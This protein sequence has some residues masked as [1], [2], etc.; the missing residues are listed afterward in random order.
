MRF[1][2]IGD[3][4]WCKY[5]SII[6]MRG[7]EYSYRLEN[8]IQS[9]TWAEELTSDCDSVIYLGDFFDHPELS[10]EE[11]TAIKEIKW[12]IKPH[13]FLVGNHEMGTNDLTYSSCHLFEYIDTYTGAKVVDKPL[14]VHFGDV[15]LHFIPYI[16]EEQ[17]KPFAEYL[18]KAPGRKNIVLSHNDISGMNLG[19]FISINGFN[20]EEI[21]QECDLFLNGHL[22]NGTKVADKVINVGNLTGQNFSEDAYLY[23]HC[24]LILNTDTMQCEVYEN[25]YAMNF[26]KVDATLFDFDVSSLKPRSAVTLKTTVDKQE[27]YKNLLS[28]ADNIIAS[29]IILVPTEQEMY[30]EQNTAEV[31]SVNH[32][33]KF[34][35]YILET[36]GNT[37]IV[38]EELQEVLK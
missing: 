1:G 5:S 2:I 15:S 13:Y 14:T 37:K 31:F 8:C 36:L 29:R 3:I 20:V 17:R 21:Q 26:Y 10:A 4:H 30:Q 16:L 33:N 23:D 28:E 9:I 11:I 35:E 12:N 7:D 24:I 19:R 38:R 27:Y 25:P 6:R 32:L 18:S 22:H 34:N